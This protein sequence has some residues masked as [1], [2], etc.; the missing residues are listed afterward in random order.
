MLKIWKKDS[1]AVEGVLKIIP[2]YIYQLSDNET[3]ADVIYPKIWNGL[4]IFN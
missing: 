1:H 2:Q 3:G 4:C